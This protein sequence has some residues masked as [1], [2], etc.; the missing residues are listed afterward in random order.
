M[1]SMDSC[2]HMLQLKYYRQAG[3]V[4]LHGNYLPRLGAQSVTS[5]VAFSGP[6]RLSVG[7]NDTNGKVRLRLNEM[8]AVCGG[9]E[10][11]WFC[12]Q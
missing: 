9:G 7:S 11:M 3:A 12:G 2:K 6:S 5:E 8:K 4:L 10:V 1:L